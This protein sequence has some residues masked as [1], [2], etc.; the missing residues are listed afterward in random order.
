MNKISLCLQLVIV[1]DMRSLGQQSAIRILEP[2]HAWYLCVGYSEKPGGMVHFIIQLHDCVLCDTLIL[3]E[4]TASTFCIFFF[5]LCCK[6]TY[7]AVNI[8]SGCLWMKERKK[9]YMTWHFQSSPFSPSASKKGRGHLLKS[10][11]VLT[12]KSHQHSLILILSITVKCGKNSTLRLC[13]KFSAVYLESRR[14]QG[15]GNPIMSDPLTGMSGEA[16][17]GPGWLLVALS[18]IPPKG[19]VSPLLQQKTL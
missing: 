16:W 12:L 4:N 17:G 6:C 11:A 19:K 7:G 1:V 5:F 10:L 3:N 18:L 13:W 8:G 15:R 14:S 9:E 2:L